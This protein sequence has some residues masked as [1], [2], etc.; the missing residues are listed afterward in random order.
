MGKDAESYLEFSMQSCKDAPCKDDFA[1][2][3]CLSLFTL[4]I[5]CRQGSGRPYESGPSSASL[6][7][8]ISKDNQLGYSQFISISSLRGLNTY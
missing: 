8:K 3:Y 2:G 4:Y 1:L 5:E 7:W 6:L